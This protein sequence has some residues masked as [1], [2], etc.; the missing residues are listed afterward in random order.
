MTRVAHAAAMD[1]KSKLQEVAAE[2]LGGKPEY[3]EVAHERVF[4][5]VVTE[6]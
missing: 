4:A 3:Y 6:E 2:T 1:A 5:K